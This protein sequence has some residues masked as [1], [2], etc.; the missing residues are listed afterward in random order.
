MKH[1]IICLLMA[2]TQ[3]IAVAAASFDTHGFGAKL[4]GWRKDLGIAV[5]AFS[6]TSYMAHKPAVTHS[7]SGL[8]FLSARV[9]LLAHADKGAVCQLV[10]SFSRFGLLETIQVKGRVHGKLMDTATVRR[11]E[12]IAKPLGT[13]EG[14]DV[15]TKPV[16]KANPTDEMLAEVFRRFDQEL[17]KLV[18]AQPPLR[19]DLFSRLSK[20]QV[21]TADLSGGLRQHVHLILQHVRSR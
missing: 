18:K 12:F 13:E 7:P 17:N 14:E 15:A 19:R 10:M 6:N 16:K 4:K 11:S 9:D 20:Q 21:E 2:F 3:A 1:C 8:M 5:F